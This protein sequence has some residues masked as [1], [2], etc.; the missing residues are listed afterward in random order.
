MQTMHKFVMIPMEYEN[1]MVQLN[2]CDTRKGFDENRVPDFVW[3]L[4]MIV[5]I[6]QVQFYDEYDVCSMCYN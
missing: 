4:S 5:S 3:K 2:A 6:G 1:Y